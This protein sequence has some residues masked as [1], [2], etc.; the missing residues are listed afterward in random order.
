MANLKE[1]S[2]TYRFGDQVKENFVPWESSKGRNTGDTKG[3]E[4]PI[5]TKTMGANEEDDL[6][7]LR[8]R[9]GERDVGG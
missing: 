3:R 8:C 9:E 4:G 5:S 7:L 6:G 2:A 1:R